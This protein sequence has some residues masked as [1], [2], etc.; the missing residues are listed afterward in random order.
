[1]KTVSKSAAA[2]APGIKRAVTKT[3]TAAKTITPDGTIARVK[4]VAQKVAHQ[5]QTAVVEGV[6]TLRD[7]G[8]SIV[9]RVTG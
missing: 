6:E 7:L 2:K 1:V 4:R 3:V 5:A 9:E 8:G